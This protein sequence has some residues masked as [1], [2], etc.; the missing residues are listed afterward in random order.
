M[1]FREKIDAIYAEDLLD[2]EGYEYK[3]TH[4]SSG[5]QVNVYTCPFC[6]GSDWKVFINRETGVGNCFHG[7]CGVTFNKTKMI[8]AILGTTKFPDIARYVDTVS[9]DLGF[10]AGRNRPE[11][12]VASSD[13]WDLP[14]SIEL[15][16]P[17]GQTLQYLMDRGFDQDVARRHHLR[18]CVSGW[19]NFDKPDGST[20]GQNFSERVIIPVFDI[21]GE[22]VT[23]QGRDITGEA[24]RKYLFP[25][26]L[27]GTSAFLYNAHNV[28]KKPAIIINEG[29]TD[30]WRTELNIQDT[31]FEKFG[32]VGSFGIKFSVGRDGR[33]QMHALMELK[34]K[35]L[36]SAIVMWD[37]EHKAFDQALQACETILRCGLTAEVA[38][39]PQDKDPGELSRSETLAALNKRIRVRNRGDIARA[40]L[41]NPYKR[42]G[43]KSA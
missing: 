4:G 43:R 14:D 38:K 36:R 28:V 31:D 42:K 9:D 40:R 7:S 30:V 33:D 17:D 34:K 27:P 32:V 21:N 11:I 22:M 37:G 5:E 15:P 6:G 24:E 8:G 2:R 13:D 26:G 29:A 16:T 35:G 3:L 20:G 18:Y 1:G 19:Y 23:F 10:S 41:F 12:E 39:L 25:S